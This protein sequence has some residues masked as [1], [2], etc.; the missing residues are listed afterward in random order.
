MRHHR[1]WLLIL[2]DAP[3][4]VP[5]PTCGVLHKTKELDR[6]M[7]DNSRIKNRKARFESARNNLLADILD[8]AASEAS[9]EQRVLD[10]EIKKRK[11]REAVH[12][13]STHETRK[14]EIELQI[15]AEEKRK[16]TAAHR[17]AAITREIQIDQLRQAGIQNPEAH[18]DG[19][20][21]TAPDTGEWLPEQIQ[22]AAANLRQHAAMA[23]VPLTPTK[24]PPFVLLGIGAFAVVAA[25]AVAGVLLFAQDV[26]IDPTAY[27][28]TT[29]TSVAVVSPS[30]VVALAMVVEPEPERQAEAVAD[31]QP[32]EE[33]SSSRRS[34]R[35]RRSERSRSDRAEEEPRNTRSTS[36]STASIS[37]DGAE[38]SLWGRGSE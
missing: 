13:M 34:R 31:S 37:L 14:R 27:P 12:R 16:E 2:H 29:V 5:F 36:P 6:R 38:D 24:R 4:P 25:M 8:E 22:Q 3:F 18:I 30:S 10:S 35:D 23:G 26:E 28:K 20:R 32:A 7:S 15:A 33:R 21:E 9:L 11:E 1:N 17:R 19:P